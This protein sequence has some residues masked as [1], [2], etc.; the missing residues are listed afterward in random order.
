MRVP[1]TYEF[2]EQ[3][4]RK[5]FTNRE[6]QP[7]ALFTSHLHGCGGDGGDA[8]HYLLE[9]DGLRLWFSN[10]GYIDNANDINLH[11]GYGRETDTLYQPELEIENEKA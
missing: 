8:Q 6:T 10:H 7:Q 5:H 4:L 9:I 3:E 2:C 1:T 11:H